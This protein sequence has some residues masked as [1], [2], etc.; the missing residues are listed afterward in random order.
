VS[1]S[2][3][4]RVGKYK[5][6]HHLDMSRKTVNVPVSLSLC[7][8]VYT[9]QNNKITWT[10]KN[11]QTQRRCYK[12]FSNTSYHW[13][14]C[15]LNFPYIHSSKALCVYNPMG[16]VSYNCNNSVS[17]G[18]ELKKACCSF[19]FSIWIWKVDLNFYT[20]KSVWIINSDLFHF[21]MKPNKTLLF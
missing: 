6:S 17:A 4:G 15:F 12:C 11:G 16:T 8:T 5:T 21:T 18:V 20:I 14:K 19:Q 2:A 1:I 3:V 7:T 9:L 10:K 13:Y